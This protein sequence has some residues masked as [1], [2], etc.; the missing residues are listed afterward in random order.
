MK[1]HAI[2]RAKGN[3]APLF[4]FSFFFFL[5]FLWLATTTTALLPCLFTIM[6]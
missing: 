6:T 3:G 4:S 1:K 2:E 5:F